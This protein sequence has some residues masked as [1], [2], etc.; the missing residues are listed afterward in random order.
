MVKW[1]QEEL[2]RMDEI[3]CTPAG[4]SCPPC[5]S[6][7][8]DPQKQQAT[9][10]NTVQ[11]AVTVAMVAKTLQHSQAPAQWS[12][13]AH[14]KE[15]C[16]GGSVGG[17]GCGLWKR[18]GEPCPHCSLAPNRAQVQA[19]MQ[20]QDK[21]GALLRPSTAAGRRS[22]WD[23]LRASR[24]SS[25]PGKPGADDVIAKWSRLAK[26]NAHVQTAKRQTAPLMCQIHTK[27]RCGG[28]TLSGQGC[29]LWKPKGQACPHCALA[30]NRAQVQAAIEKA[31]QSPKP[32]AWDDILLPASAPASRRTSRELPLP[33]QARIDKW[34]RLARP[35]AHVQTEKRPTA[36]LPSQIHV[37]ER[38]G[39]GSV[40]GLGCGLWKQKG[41]PCPHCE[42]RPNRWQ[43]AIAA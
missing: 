20:R 4:L 41:A 33:M 17:M 21:T 13:T 19:A 39:G 40:G 6:A 7:P 12:A 10:A 34:S 22:S 26:P 43:V 36:P 9:L 30:P 16:G 38:C 5:G 18:K 25:A 24:P 23:G 35:N 14:T 11:K 32:S 1:N 2:D 8:F 27:E 15:R 31:A 3:S 42:T 28:G 29:G 37:K